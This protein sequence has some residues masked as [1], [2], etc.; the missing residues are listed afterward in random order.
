MAQKF[1][2]LEEAAAQ[3]GITKDRL[4]DLREDGK[5]RA[6]R[7]GASWKFRADDIEKLA[8]DGLPPDASS[9]DLSLGLDEESA[10]GA[11]ASSIELDDITLGSGI[12]LDLGDDLELGSE[13]ELGDDEPAEASAAASDLSLDDLDEPTLPV[14]GPGDVLELDTGEEIDEFSDSILLSENELGE[15]TDRPP[16]TII[17]KA[18]M[19]ADL[20]L[21]LGPS[22]D[23]AARMSD[24]RLAEPSTSNVFASGIGDAILDTE[25]PNLEDNF[26]DLDELEID[27]EA[28]SSRILA[29]E[30]VAKAQQ[31]ASKVKSEAKAAEM[32]DLELAASD[33]SPG[34]VL[35]GLSGKSD[36][37]L[38]GL[39]ALELEGDDDDVLGDGS[40][41]TLSSESSGINII[42]P[43]DSGLAL[44]E[45]P[46]AMGSGSPLASGLDLGPTSDAEVGLEP[47][48]VAEDGGEEP[49][50]LTPFGEETSDEEEDSSQVIPLD[51]VSE[52][53]GGGLLGTGRTVGV[54][55]I[56]D[57]FA[58]LP[59]GGMM[60]VGETVADVAFPGW[61][62][63]LMSVSMLM[64]VMCGMMV[65]DL[66]RNIWS[67][68]QVYTLNSGLMDVLT[69]I[70]G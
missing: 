13:I 44:D 38:A 6:Y 69:P 58:A 16:S 52:E 7:D 3:L 47:L 27:L 68:D 64:L 42:S 48:E 12:D 54:E 21:D 56:G 46:L 10:S 43:S 9:S 61:V 29:P 8:V 11:G 60:P 18:E 14:D 28:E 15:S 24:V 63:G 37:A 62:I 57:D 1:V 67:W 19:A 30:D 17:G 22:E 39:S 65:F 4:N 36:I 2:S 51:E 33:S 45:V 35:E 41:I 59:T 53:E 20:D 70:L 32:S 66:L 40:D 31:A 25:P 49:F 23:D 55:S 26:G 34:G 50:A 5:V